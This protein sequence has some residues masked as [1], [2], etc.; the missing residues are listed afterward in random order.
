VRLSASWS[1]GTGLSAATAAAEAPL[2]AAL[3]E[4][5]AAR[6]QAEHFGAEVEDRA[7]ASAAVRALVSIEA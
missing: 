1:A 2:A 4:V 7:A 5:A 3:A 6:R